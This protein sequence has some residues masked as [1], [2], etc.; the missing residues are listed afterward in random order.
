MITLRL[1]P[2]IDVEDTEED[3]LT[4]EELFDL[5][6]HSLNITPYSTMY[7]GVRFKSGTLRSE[8][9]KAG[10]THSFTFAEY[11]NDTETYLYGANEIASIGSIAPY[12]CSYIKLTP[13]TKLTELKIGHRATNYDN[14]NLAKIEIGTKNLLKMIDLRNCSGLGVKEDNGVVQYNLD[15]SNCPNIEHIYTEGTNLTSVTLP[16]GG[17]VKTLH[18]PGTAESIT[19]KNQSHLQ[20]DGFYIAPGKSSDGSDI[21]AYSRV[22]QIEIENCPALDTRKLLGNCLTYAKGALRVSLTGL[23]ANKW[24]FDDT[25]FIKSLFSKRDSSGRLI[26]GTVNPDNANE[27]ARISGTCYIKDL[28]GADYADIKDCYPALNIQFGEMTSIVTFEYLVKDGDSYTKQTKTTD[29]HGL[30]SEAGRV[31]QEKLTELAM[32]PAWPENVAFAYEFKGW[33]TLKQEL[34]LKEDK[35]DRILEDS[36]YEDEDYLREIYPDIFNSLS[37]QG[38]IGNRTLYPVFKVIRKSYDITF[39]NPTAQEDEQT[40]AVISTPYGGDTDYAGA[41]YAI[42]TK[43]DGASPDLYEFTGWYPSPEKITGEMICEAQFAVKDQD[44]PNGDDGDT[45]PGYTIGWFDITNCL[46]Y[47]GNLLN[48][49]GFGYSTAG[50]TMSIFECNNNFNSAVNIPATMTLDG[51]TYT[52]TSLGG[53]SGHDKLELVYLPNTLI[54]LQSRAFAGCN[55]LTEVELPESL[56]TISTEAL[57]ACTKLKELNIPVNVTN[58]SDAAFASCINLEKITVAEGN[59]KFEVA[60]DCLID[61]QNNKL[62]HAL[63][64]GTIPESVTSLGNYCFASLPIRSIAIPDNISVIS[65]NAFSRCEQLVDVTLPSTLTKLDATCFAWCKSLSD[66][67]LPDGLVD[68]M[69]YV[70]DACA[71]VNVVIPASVNNVLDRS[72][73]DMSSLNVVTFNRA[74]A[75]RIPYIHHGAFYNSGSQGSPVTFN[76]PWTKEQHITTFKGTYVENEV[77]KDKDIFFGSCKGSMLRFVDEAGNVVDEVVKVTEGVQSDVNV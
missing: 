50:N 65:N 34:A 53:F 26:G 14:P 13:A 57:Q 11:S 36:A 61:K 47:Q 37:L 62:L 19:I 49:T 48:G 43:Q 54:E 44:G 55:N 15:L 75:G 38:I 12:R 10:D 29:V 77:T 25:N 60:N 64:T 4:E 41:G 20:D 27:E 73:G 16:D 35:L 33:S 46:D 51:T 21:E 22:S 74:T 6:A 17:H 70:F 7:A 5:N 2:I 9:V 68:I 1:N 66:I 8:L 23:T 52:V 58:I 40:L 28:T 3:N 63:V 30:N 59:T 18:L 45:L 76:L 24:S 72:F 42:P 67:T 31:T 32:E 71:L 56:Q 69:T 39:V